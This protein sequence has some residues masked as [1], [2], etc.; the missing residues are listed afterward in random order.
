MNWLWS[1]IVGKKHASGL[2]RQIELF[3]KAAKEL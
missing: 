3:I 2:P 1:R